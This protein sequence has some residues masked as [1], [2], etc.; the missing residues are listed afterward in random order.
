[1]SSKLTSTSYTT[2]CDE[3]VAVLLTA[4][5]RARQIFERELAAAYWQ[6]G[7]LSLAHLLTHGGRLRARKVVRQVALG[8]MQLEVWL[9]GRQ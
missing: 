8:K 9:D 2:L 1:M 5:E 6:V 7:Q 4:R 3:V